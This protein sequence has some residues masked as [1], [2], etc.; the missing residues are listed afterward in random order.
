MLELQTKQMFELQAL[1]S[2]GQWYAIASFTT[3]HAAYDAMEERGGYKGGRVQYR[4]VRV[5]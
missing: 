3:S 2:S 1:Q 4:V 5:S